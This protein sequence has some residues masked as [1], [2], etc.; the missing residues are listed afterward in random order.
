VRN[1]LLAA[2][3]VTLG[4][5]F[6]ASAQAASCDD[7]SA[8]GAFTVHV[9][10]DSVA[11]GRQQIV[12]VVGAEGVFYRSGNDWGRDPHTPASVAL[13]DPTAATTKAGAD[14]I[15]AL[16]IPSRTGTVGATVSWTQT[17]GTLSDPD[18]NTLQCHMSRHIE[19][20]AVTGKAPPVTI[21]APPPGDYE[22]NQVNAGITLKGCRADGW[23]FAIVPVVWKLHWTTNGSAPSRSSRTVT[24]GSPDPCFTNA[25]DGRPGTVT[26]PKRIANRTF[27]AN[28]AAISYATVVLIP[29]FKSRGMRGWWEVFAG[30]RLVKS[31]R[32]KWVHGSG[33]RTTPAGRFPITGDRLEHDSGPCPGLR[34]SPWTPLP[35]RPTS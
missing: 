10:F 6:S 22:L 7:A 15:D 1:A 24:W 34:C 33:F 18:G 8:Q 35:L 13:D 31:V 3:L 12:S 32:F 23:N 16:I 11:V 4:L 19:F 20:A 30:G 29:A 2:S 14:D 21:L 26:G 5:A 28:R 9:S 17:S 27:V 25:L